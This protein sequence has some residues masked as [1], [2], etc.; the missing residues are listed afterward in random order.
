MRLNKRWISGKNAEKARKYG[1]AKAIMRKWVD[2][3]EPF[4]FRHERVAEYALRPST[5]RLMASIIAHNENR[6]GQDA[7]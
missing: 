7:D 2:S 4:D 1:K 6:G 3:L 5:V